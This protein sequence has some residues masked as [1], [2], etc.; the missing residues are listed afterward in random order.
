MN[1]PTRDPEPSGT[2]FLAPIDSSRAILY[3]SLSTGAPSSTTI[4]RAL[5]MVFVGNPAFNQ[6]PPRYDKTLVPRSSP[7]CGGGTLSADEYNMGLHV[8]ALFVVLAQSTIACAFPIIAKRC[9]KLR[10]PPSF[11][12]FAR[13][14]GTGVLVATAFVHLLPT[15]FI[16]L[17]DPCLPEFWNDKYPAMPGAIAMCAVFLVTAVEMVFTRGI[18]KGTFSQEDYRMATLETGVPANVTGKKGKE[19][20]GADDEENAIE[21]EE[22]ED[23]ENRPPSSQSEKSESIGGKGGMGK[24][25][26]GMLGRRRSRSHS[27]GQSLQRLSELSRA[28]SN[29]HH[30]GNQPEI[31]E[32]S[33]SRGSLDGTC[34]PEMKPQTNMDK[35]L[36]HH[37]GHIPRSMLSPQ[38]L[39]KKATLQVFMLEMGIL[40]HSVFIGMALSVTVGPAFIVLLIAIIFHQTF[41]GLAL[42]SRIAVLDWKKGSWQP[43]IM[44]LAYGLTTPIGQAIGLGT[45]T[46]YAPDS[47]TGLLMVGIMN[48]ISSGLLVFAGLVELLAEDF[49]S[50]ESWHTLV[51]KRRLMACVWVVLGAASMSLVGAWA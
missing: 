36:I 18:C 50:D 15:A 33:E 2:S 51:G 1:C 5:T 34:R 12:F 39:R 7:V 26:F 38:Q 27:V 31:I 23:V 13:H 6:S 43:W 10:I 37:H 24:M 35:A 48:A 3:L 19:T 45:H 32:I 40:F 49:L 21:E 28:R 14:F 41:E 22:E 25:G 11:L 44:A 20:A 9:P 42:G 29:H 30:G 16:S 8:M 4:A 47:Q 17:L 46:L